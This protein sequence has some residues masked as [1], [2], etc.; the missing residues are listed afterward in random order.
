M[1]HKV[2]PVGFRLGIIRDWEA[3]WYSEGSYAEY[4]KEDIKIRGAIRSN[5]RE[6]AIS[7]LD[8][9][10]Q[11]K[12][13]TI[14]LNYDFAVNLGW[15][16]PGVIGSGFVGKLDGTGNATASWTFKPDMSMNGLTFYLAYV[17]LSDGMKM[18]L[19]AASNHVNATCVFVQ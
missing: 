18:P 9:N 7:T 14:P 10:R 19:L 5:Y 8:I 17:V 2:H 6:A 4:L 15:M 13:V 1:G 16:V 11:A 12:D 3:K